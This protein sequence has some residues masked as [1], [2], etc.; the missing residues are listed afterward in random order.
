MC[1]GQSQKMIMKIMDLFAGN[2]ITLDFD[3]NEEE[4]DF[5][6]TSFVGFLEENEDL[7][8]DIEEETEDCVHDH[9]FELIYESDE[10]EEGATGQLLGL[11]FEGKEISEE[12]G[13]GMFEKYKGLIAE[14][15]VEVLDLVQENIFD[16]EFQESDIE[17]AVRQY[18]SV[19][20]NEGDIYEVINGIPLFILDGIVYSIIKNT[21]GEY[22]GN[23][24]FDIGGGW[25]DAVIPVSI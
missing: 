25:L 21:I 13:V 8:M 10:E 11:L 18:F 15:E 2:D 16:K 24:H 6:R 19:K 20:K 12:D 3:W 9:L 17:D 14:G 23:L 4:E 7:L 22:E 5:G 1:C